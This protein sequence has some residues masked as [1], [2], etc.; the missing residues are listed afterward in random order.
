MRSGLS[1]CRPPPPES[2]RPGLEPGSPE[3]GGSVVREKEAQQ[4]GVDKGGASEVTSEL[5]G[6]QDH[7]SEA[8]YHD[9]RH[10]DDC[11]TGETAPGLHSQIF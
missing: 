7:Q 2:V 1:G 4:H 9:A 8:T 10:V 5:L 6:V 3:H 11:Q